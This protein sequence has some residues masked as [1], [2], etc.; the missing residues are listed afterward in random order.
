MLFRSSPVHSVFDHWWTSADGSREAMV[1]W[2][3]YI[4]FVPVDDKTTQIVSLTYAKSR[5]PGPVGSLRLMRWK[6]RQQIDREIRADV[7]MLHHLA[8]YDSGMDGLKLSR[9]DKVMGLTRERIAKIYR[10]DARTPLQLAE[11]G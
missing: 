9:F 8:D 2:R 3:L 4:F 11:T 6:M 1:R 7:D 5:Y 10:G